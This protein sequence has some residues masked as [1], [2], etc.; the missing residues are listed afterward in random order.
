[1]LCQNI[2]HYSALCFLMFS[3][4]PIEMSVYTIALCA[5]VSMP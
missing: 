5:S 1:M 4:D 2:I 3:V